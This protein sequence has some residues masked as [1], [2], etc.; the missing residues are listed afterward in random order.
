MR[1]NAKRWLALLPALAVAM[2]AAAAVS[3]Q[4]VCS[5]TALCTAENPDL[6]CPVCAADPAA[7]QFGA[8][9]PRAA[10]TQPL[11]FTAGASASGDGYA[12]DG[13][14]LTGALEERVR[15][16]V[17]AAEDDTL[18]CEARYLDLVDRSNGNSWVLSDQPV[19][20][21]WGYPEGAGPDASYTLLHLQGLH[22]GLGSITGD[23]VSQWADVVAMD[24]TPTENGI[25]FTVDPGDF[26]PFVLL[27]E[28]PAAP[29][30]TPAPT[31]A[32]AA[33]APAAAPVALS[34]AVPA[35]G[36]NSALGLWLLL[37][38]LAVAALVALA[39]LEVRR[40]KK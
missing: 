24:I 12:W 5:C 40:R 6:T 32:P 3:A 17:N 18:A 26:S 19:T 2:A 8:A 30:P 15:A 34:A 16:F 1:A 13:D 39:I 28:E 20:I 23:V 27:W 22:R 36:D 10:V 25:C 14:T 21:F 35:T 9:T 31:A 29:A 11:A 4:D 38:A 37:A 7:C 33:P